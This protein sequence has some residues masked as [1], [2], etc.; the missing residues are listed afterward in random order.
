MSAGRGA[1]QAAP[2]FAP[3]YLA[4]HRSGELKQRGQ[5]L[6]SSME[7]CRLCPRECG[8]NKLK[9]ATVEASDLRAG[10]SLVLAGLAAEGETRVRNIHFVDRG[11]E[12]LEENLRTLGATIERVPADHAEVG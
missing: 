5:E 7:R 3:A 11:Y 4:L 2:A 1:A 9:G 8:V 12:N 10:A 6:W